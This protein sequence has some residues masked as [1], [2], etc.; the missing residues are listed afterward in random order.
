M[1]AEGVGDGEVA[2]V[3]AELEAEMLEASAKLEF[4]KAA[5]IRDQISSLKGGGSGDRAGRGP[6]KGGRRKVGR[7]KH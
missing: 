2:K 7:G 4:E 5:I 6:K 3:I 1:V